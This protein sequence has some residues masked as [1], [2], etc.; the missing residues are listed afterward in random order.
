MDGGSRPVLRSSREIRGLRSGKDRGLGSGKDRGICSGNG[1]DPRSGERSAPTKTETPAPAK[2]EDSA[3]ARVEDP[4]SPAKTT[5]DLSNGGLVIESGAN[6]LTIGALLQVRGVAENREVFDADAVGPGM[7]VPDGTVGSFQISRARLFLGGT[8][9][10]RWLRWAIQMAPGETSS[11]GVG[12]LKDA[13]FQVGR[14]DLYLRAGQ[15][16]VPFSLQELIPDFYQGFIERSLAV[17]TFSI[18]RD[19]GTSGLAAFAK[20]KATLQ[21]GVFNGSGEGRMHQTKGM[22][23]AVRGALQPLG[24]VKMYENSFDPAEPTRLHLG[25]GYHWGVPSKGRILTGQFQETNGQAGLGL[26]AMARGGRAVFYSEI[27]FERN[28]ILAE[29]LTAQTHARGFYVQAG[30]LI[31]AQRLQGSL[32]YSLVDPNT[33]VAQDLSRE[34]RMALQWA[35]VGH[36]LKFQADAGVVRFEPKASGRSPRLPEADG[37]VVEDVTARLQLQ[38]LF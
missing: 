32:R 21:A 33:S 20:R 4:P 25:A 19:V 35:V 10:R 13:W 16:K 24:E 29:T 30:W 38:L 3:P 18:G 26:E 22:L 11:E 28:D 14:D 31:L 8:V 36:R 15:H 37:R 2:S 5:V 6:R 27:F 9:Y 1:R 12:R 7:G 17:L 34:A 23:Y